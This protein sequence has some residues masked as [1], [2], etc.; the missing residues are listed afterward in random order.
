MST[1]TF[2]ATTADGRRVRIT[3]DRETIAR[4]MTYRLG[5]TRKLKRADKVSL[6]KWGSRAAVVAEWITP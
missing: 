5:K 1:E 4:E 3:I 6:G 2:E